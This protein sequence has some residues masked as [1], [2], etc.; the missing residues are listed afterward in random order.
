MN[1]LTYKK[2]RRARSSAGE[3]N[4]TCGCQKDYLSYPALYT[5]VKNKHNGIFPIG[6]NAKK[7]ILDNNLNDNEQYFQIN[8]KSF[9]LDLVNFLYEKK[10]ISEKLI[11]IEKNFEVIWTVNQEKL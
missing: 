11:D 8:Q 2:K 4:Y 7:T 5:H 10:F 6:S 9:F 1:E 3:R